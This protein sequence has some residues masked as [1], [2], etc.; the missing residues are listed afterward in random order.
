[1]SRTILCFAILCLLSAPAWAEDYH[2]IAKQA[3]QEA[4]QDKIQAKTQPASDA[5]VSKALGHDHAAMTASSGKSP[6]AKTEEQAAVI[7]AYQDANT[8]MHEAMNVAFTGDADRDFIIGM[9][10]HHQGAVDMARI[11]LENGNDPEIRKLAQAIIKAQQK[12]IA[13]MQAW[14][15]KYDGKK[16]VN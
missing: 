9:I 16:K 5:A 15:K 8:K 3:V 14:L 1:M 4:I 7:Q 12:E 10:P 6:S 2:A 11:V 13:Q